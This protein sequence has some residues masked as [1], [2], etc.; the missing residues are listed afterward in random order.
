[1]TWV[2]IDLSALWQGVPDASS[3]PGWHGPHQTESDVPALKTKVLTPDNE[4]LVM[5]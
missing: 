3:T 1:M 2:P 5:G 4:R